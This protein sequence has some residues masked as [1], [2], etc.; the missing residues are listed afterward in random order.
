[1]IY[2]I[3]IAVSCSD[4]SNALFDFKQFRSIIILLNR[5]YIFSIFFP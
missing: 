4:I 1:M 5:K 2:V 3:L